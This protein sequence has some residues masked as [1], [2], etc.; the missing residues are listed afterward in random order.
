MTYALMVVVGMVL[1]AIFFGGL[2]MTVRQMPNSRRPG[3][4]FLFSVVV[5]TTVVIGGFWYFAGGDA[6]SM[7]ACLLGFIGLR[8]LATHGTAIF[9]AAFGRRKPN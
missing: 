3:M 8:L 1:G 2:W 9:G 4:L 7:L 5:R 6:K